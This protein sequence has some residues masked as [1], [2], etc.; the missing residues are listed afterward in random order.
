MTG[1][2]SEIATQPYEPTPGKEGWR[3][4]LR[5]ANA[6]PRCNAKR[7]RLDAHCRGP[8]MPNGRCRIHGGASPGAPVRE[9]NGNYR[10][11]L[12]T[13]EAKRERKEER[14][15]R[16]LLVALIDDVARQA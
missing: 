7:R 15:V 14:A 10:S 12:W 13:S 2:A 1:G 5:E 4:G 9:R 8:A 6:A 16:A 11:G 3:K